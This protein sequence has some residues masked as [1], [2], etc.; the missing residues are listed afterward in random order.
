M[1]G[2]VEVTLLEGAGECGA[3]TRRSET[4]LLSYLQGR[5]GLGTVHATPVR[6]IVA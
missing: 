5:R 2:S 4:C 1:R 3:S 6:R